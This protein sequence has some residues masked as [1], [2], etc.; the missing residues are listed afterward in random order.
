MLPKAIINNIN[1]LKIIKKV[2]TNAEIEK[3]IEKETED[4]EKEKIDKKEKKKKIAKIDK[5]PQ[6]KEWEFHRIIY[7]YGYPRMVES[8]FLDK[9]VSCS[10]NFDLSLHIVI[11]FYIVSVQQIYNKIQYLANYY[12]LIV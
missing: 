7:A 8:G 11:I 1:S 2:E 12:D 5:T 3:R 6:E 9:L 4:I 10:G